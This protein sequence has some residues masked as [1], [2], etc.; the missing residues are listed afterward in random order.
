[1]NTATKTDIGNNPLYIVEEGFNPAREREIETIL[2]IGNGYM[3]TR[4]SLEEYYDISDP[5]T[6]VS[7]IYEKDFEYNYNVLVDLPDWTRMQVFVNDSLIDL[8]N[9]KILEHVRYLDFNQ[10]LCV[11]KWKSQDSEGRITNIKTEKFISLS[12]KHEAGKCITVTP[13]NYSGKIKILSGI[14]GNT[15]DNHFLTLERIKTD[16]YINISVKTC[17]TNRSVSFCQR[18]R[19]LYEDLEFDYRTKINNNLVYEEWEWQ[20]RQNTAYTIIGLVSVYSSFDTPN[21][22]NCSKS[23]L[24]KLEND[25][26]NDSFKQHKIKLQERWN[27][28][29]VIISDNPDDQK[30]FNFAIFHL[31][32]SGEF[33]GDYA[34]IPARNLTGESY[35]GHIFWDTEIYLLPFY[36][37]TCPDIARNLLLYRYNT[38]SDARENARNEGF[39]GASFAWESTVSGIEM[40]PATDILPTGEKINIHTG[41]FENHIGPGISYAVWQYWLITQDQDFLANYGAEIIFEIARFCKSLLRKGNDGFYHVPQVIGPDEYHELVD[42]NAYTNFMIQFNLNIAVRLDE[43]LTKNY[44]D[45]Y[46]ELKSRIS[47][48]EEEIKAWSEIK[49][50]IYIGYDEDSNIYEQFK[51]YFDLEYINVKDYEPR[52]A[53][54][55]IILGIEK[56]KETQV[57]KQPD[58]IMFLFLLANEFS[59]E[60]IEANY[61]YYEPRTGHGSSLSP[62]IYSTVAARLEKADQAYHYFEQGAHIDLGNNMGNA[63]GG[64]HIAA[65]GGLWMTVIMGFAGLYIYDN[66]LLFDPHLPEKWERLKF[67]LLWRNQKLLIEISRNEMKF[68]IIGNQMIRLSIGLDNWKELKPD[69]EYFACKDKNWVWK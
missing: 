11:R 44:Q 28:S 34:S 16:K 33:S 13:E 43:W 45:K 5:G 35:K 17:H 4:N 30:A 23:H 20:A 63:A 61:D 31:I 62:S 8:F 47:L 1:M 53:A 25:F 22:A 10:G 57:I 55:D 50:K 39:E 68:Q 12:N 52:T 3:G 56:T 66:G 58:V 65:M 26:Y 6:Y 54:M 42:D 64:I 2:S 19:F 41:E 27:Q 14:D 15:A 37:L 18:S 24:S 32:M 38:L 48:R 40:A 49:D 36:T 46:K 21:P 9:S 7:G 29:R 51:G 59:R 69:N 67:P 60:V